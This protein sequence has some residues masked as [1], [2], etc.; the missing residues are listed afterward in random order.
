MACAGDTPCH[1]PFMHENLMD[2]NHQF[3]HRRLMGRVKPRLLGHAKG[4]GWVEAQYRFGNEGGK[5]HRGASWLIIGGS[6]DETNFENI[7]IRTACSDPPPTRT[8][9]KKGSRA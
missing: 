5:K 6:G 4:D 1:Y 8:A 7:N 3:L 9:S 2:M